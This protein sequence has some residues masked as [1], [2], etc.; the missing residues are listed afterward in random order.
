MSSSYSIKSRDDLLMENTLIPF[1]Q[2]NMSRFL[3]VVG[4]GSDISLR[5]IDWFVTNY[6]KQYGIHYEI[7]RPNR[8]PRHFYVY[9]EYKNQLAGHGKKYF[10]PFRRRSRILFKYR[11]SGTEPES[12]I[13]TTVA[14]LNFFKWAIENLIIDY[15]R[16]HLQE[17]IDDMNVRNVKL[18]DDDS[19]NNSEK[20]RKRELSVASTRKISQHQMKT[21]L[22]FHKKEM[23][24]AK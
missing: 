14:Q 19:S 9:N 17:I 4:E 10:D 13:E 11:L 3:D 16:S 12:S 1:Y 18:S 2:H 8:M 21:V 5:V 24:E 20:R 6:S 7:R 15:V 23:C 22:H